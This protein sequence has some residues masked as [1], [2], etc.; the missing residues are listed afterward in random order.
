[1]GFWMIFS[2][3]EVGPL[4]VLASFLPAELLAALPE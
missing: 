3:L 4:W 2:S 1:M